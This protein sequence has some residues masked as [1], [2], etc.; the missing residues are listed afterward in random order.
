MRL[1]SAVEYLLH[2]HSDQLRSITL[3]P[4][5]KL[6]YALF[7]DYAELM[8][9]DTPLA[10]LVF[11]SPTDYL[12]FFDRAAT[13]AHKRVL[14]DMVSHEKG[15]EKKFIHVRFNVCGSPLE[16]PETFPRIGRVWVKHRGILL[17][18]KGTVIRSGAVKL[19]EGERTYQC[20]KCKHM[21]PLYPEL[22]TRNT[23]TLPSIGPSQVYCHIQTF[24]SLCCNNEFCS[25]CSS[26]FLV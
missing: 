5:P 15:V 4:D 9:D 6:H 1:H 14:K 3:S 19:Y 21:F 25:F 23:I 10:R 26:F 22:E 2:C 13:L 16:F 12:R 7:L 17:T 11:V 8:D 18:L 20:K 24:F